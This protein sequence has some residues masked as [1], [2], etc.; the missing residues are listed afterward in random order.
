MSKGASGPGHCRRQAG[1]QLLKRRSVNPRRRVFRR[2]GLPR[3]RRERGG[4][5]GATTL[6]DSRLTQ[7]EN[8]KNLFEKTWTG[9]VSSINDTYRSRAIITGHIIKLYRYNDVQ[10]CQKGKTYENRK[11]REDRTEEEK[12]KD[13]KKNLLRARN[14]LID[15]IN[16]NA[17]RPWGERLKFFTM[18]FKEDIFDL[19]E[20]NK[21]Q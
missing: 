1:R 18:S 15:T 7:G 3:G 20:A 9:Y 4:G 16:A 8:K 6:L 12:Q 21:G 2:S 11:K 13:R 17:D 10:V 5:S 14:A 19:K